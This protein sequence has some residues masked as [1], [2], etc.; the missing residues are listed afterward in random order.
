MI[1]LFILIL[2]QG[3]LVVGSECF[4]KVALEKIGEFTWTWASIKVALSTWQL[5]VAGLMAITGVLEWMAVLK[6]YD[7]S[8]AYPLTA[9]S[10]VLSLFAGSLIFHEAIPA[11]RWIGVVLVMVGVYFIAR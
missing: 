8:L 3:L 5:Y 7:L 1:R 4:L 6:R 9:I 11:T 2:L 10:F